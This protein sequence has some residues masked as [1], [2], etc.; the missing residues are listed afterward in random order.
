V[1]SH[2]EDISIPGGILAYNKYL[3]I[4]IFA[5]LHICIL[6]RLCCIAAKN[7]SVTAVSVNGKVT[8]KLLKM[9]VEKSNK[10]SVIAV[11]LGSFD[12]LLLN[13]IFL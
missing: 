7:F 1:A 6:H 12:S 8:G 3:H 4:C 9:A 10:A 2:A 11:S 13:I 5:Y